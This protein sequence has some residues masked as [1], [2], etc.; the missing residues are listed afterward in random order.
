L[1]ELSGGRVAEFTCDDIMVDPS[2]A[3]IVLRAAEPPPAPMTP[4]FILAP[5]QWI[6]ARRDSE[7]I[8][9]APESWSAP[10]GPYVPGAF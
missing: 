1:I 8:M 2:G 10:P 9:P 7:Q 5:R 6:S 4:V 3:L